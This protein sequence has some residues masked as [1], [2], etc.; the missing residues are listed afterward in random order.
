[1]NVFEVEAPDEEAARQIA[2]RI[3]RRL[4]DSHDWGRLFEEQ[5]HPEVL[6]A[7]SRMPPRE[8]RRAWMTGLGNARLKGRAQVLR[9]DLPEPGAGA[10]RPIGFVH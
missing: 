3:Y 4:L 9:D 10:A 5:P 8:M 6:D 1:M 2:L 7:M